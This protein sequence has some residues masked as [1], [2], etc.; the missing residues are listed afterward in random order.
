MA[1]IWSSQIQD[2]RVASGMVLEELKSL[3]L[4]LPKI[5]ASVKVFFIMISHHRDASIRKANDVFVLP[6]N[7]EK[8]LSEWTI[9]VGTASICH[10]LPTTSLRVRELSFAAKLLDK[11]NGRHSDLWVEMIDVDRNK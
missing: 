6:K 11:F 8:I 9:I 2:L 1:P 7:L 4:K 3:R 5:F 10:W